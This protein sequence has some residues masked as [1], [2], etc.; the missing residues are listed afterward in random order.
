MSVESCTP[1]APKAAAQGARGAH[2]AHG[3][4]G[5]KGKPS[6]AGDAGAPDAGGFSALLMQLGANDEDAAAD[7]LASSAEGAVPADLLAG[8]DRSTTICR[9]WARKGSSGKC[10]SSPFSPSRFA[11]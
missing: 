1:A 9:P 6:V 5:A 3:A 7:D 8:Q 11:R 2:G 10:F 4:H